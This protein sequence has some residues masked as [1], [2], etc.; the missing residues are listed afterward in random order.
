M[1]ISHEAESVQDVGIDWTDCFICQ[2]HGDVKL[3]SLLKSCESTE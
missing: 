1:L 2:K 3:V